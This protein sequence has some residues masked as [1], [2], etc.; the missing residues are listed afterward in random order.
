[1]ILEFLRGNPARSRCGFERG[2]P[3][4]I[5]HFSP[6]AAPQ[7]GQGIASIRASKMDSLLFFRMAGE[8]M[9]HIKGTG[10]VNRDH[11]LSV[12]LMPMRC[13]CSSIARL[14]PSD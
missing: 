9:R 2:C 12:Q 6:L 10:L 3:V 1:V 7:V 11:F 4:L 14:S 5:S 13:T 8:I